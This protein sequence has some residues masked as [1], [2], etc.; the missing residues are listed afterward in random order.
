MAAGE[1]GT[2]RQSDH[3][4]QR[5]PGP[6]NRQL[7]A[8][9][10]QPLCYNGCGKEQRFVSLP[11]PQEPKRREQ[12]ETQRDI[13]AAHLSQDRDEAGKLRR[14]FADLRQPAEHFGVRFAPRPT[15]QS[16]QERYER[17]HCEKIG[18]GKDRHSSPR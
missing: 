13:S 17:G 1:A 5:G 16:G 12:P 14:R 2:L 4:F 9:H 11:P 8:V 7:E 6:A 3:A 18:S 10:G 15:S